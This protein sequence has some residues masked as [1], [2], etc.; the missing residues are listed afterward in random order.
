[1]FRG[2]AD[3]VKS[4]LKE[5][6]SANF[7]NDLTKDSVLMAA[8]Q[9]GHAEIARLLLAAGSDANYEAPNGDSALEWAS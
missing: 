1:M 4:L 2:E 3:N 8:S 6:A 9:K 5:G 7:A